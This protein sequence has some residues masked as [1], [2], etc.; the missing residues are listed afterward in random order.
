M[1][2]EQWDVAELVEPNPDYERNRAYAKDGPYRTQLSSEE[3]RG[4]QSWVKAN[5]VPTDDSDTS[6][7]DM[8]GFYRGMKAGDEHARTGVNQNDGKLHFSDYYKTPYHKSFSRESQWATDGAPSWNDQDQLVDPRGNVVFDERAKASN[9]GWEIDTLTEPGD[10]GKGGHGLVGERATPPAPAQAPESS[11]GEVLEQMPGEYGAQ[12]AKRVS[13]AKEFVADEVRLQARKELWQLM[14]L[15]EAVRRARDEG[16]NLTEDPDVVSYAKRLG[17]RPDTFVRD[18]PSMVNLSQDERLSRQRSARDRYE[19]A[20]EDALKQRAT[21]T[22][23]Q[24]ESAA[25]RPD[26][27]PW[28]AKSIV[29]DAMQSV[30]DLLAGIGAGVAGGPPAGLAVLGASVAPG[31]YSDARDMG[32]DPHKAQIYTGL[33]TMAEIAPELPVFE[34]MLHNPVGQEAL[35]KTV[36]GMILKQTGKVAQTAAFEGVSESVT[37]ALEIGI[38]EGLIDKNTPLPQ[39][40]ERIARAGVVG[41]AMGAGVAGVHQTLEGGAERIAHGSERRVPPEMRKEP[42]LGDV[43][44]PVSSATTPTIPDNLEAPRESH[45]GDITVEAGGQ[46]AQSVDETAPESAPVAQGAWEVADLVEPG[47]PNPEAEH[48][49]FQNQPKTAATAE[50]PVEAPPVAGTIA[51][52]APAEASTPAVAQ[53]TEPVSVRTEGGPEVPGA[54]IPSPPE[55]GNNAPA[56]EAATPASEWEVEHTTAPVDEAAHAAAT[57]PHNALPEPTH[58]QKEAG[59]YQKGHLRLHGLDISIENP[60]GSTRSSHPGAKTQ[61]QVQ[62]P[63]HYG[64]VRRT[65]GADGEHVDITLGPHA[66]DASKPVFVIDQ[67]R[68][69]TLK[70]D[71]TKSFMGFDSAEQVLEAYRGSFEGDFGKKMAKGVTPRQFTL[72]QYKD[73]LA[74]GDHTKPVAEYGLAGTSQPAAQDQK[75]TEIGHLSSPPV[76]EQQ[77]PIADELNVAS[78]WKNELTEV[79][80]QAV[81]QAAGIKVPKRMAWTYLKPEER[82]KV[83]AVRGTDNDPLES[84]RKARHKAAE[85]WDEKV[86]Q[87]FDISVEGRKVRVKVSSGFGVGRAHVEYFGSAISPTG[88]RSTWQSVPA[89]MTHEEVQSS[90]QELGPRLRAESLK[91]HK[92]SAKKPSPGDSLAA[93]MARGKHFNRFVLDHGDDPDIVAAWKAVQSDYREEEEHTD[94]PPKSFLTG[95]WAA[96][97]GYKYDAIEHF[98][99]NVKATELPYLAGFRAGGGKIP[100]VAEKEPAVEAVPAPAQTE[101]RGRQQ[102]TV[103]GR[104]GEPADVGGTQSPEGVPAAGVRGAEEER[105]ARADTAAPSPLDTAGDGRAAGARDEPGRGVAA[106]TGEVPDHAG[107]AGEHPAGDVGPDADRGRS[108]LVPPAT[109]Q[110]ERRAELVPPATPA[111]N[112]IITAADHLGEGGQKTKA[113]QNLDAI[114]ILK[115]LAKSGAAATR[116]QQEALVKYVGWGGIPQIFDTTKAEWEELRTDLAG[117]LTPEEFAAARRS[118]QD[119]HYTSETVVRGMWRALSRMGFNGGSV[120]E[121]SVGVGHFFGMMPAEQRTGTRAVGVELDPIT[122]GIAKLLYPGDRVHSPMGFQDFAVA[123]DS[124]DLAIGNPPFGNQSLYDR[125]RTELNP[126]SIHNYFFAKSINA[127]RPGG[128]L[129]MVVSNYFLDAQT[130]SAREY[131]SQRANLVA[132]IRLP[133]TA[134]K[135]NAGT[136]VVTD[137]I[138]LRKRMP[139]EESN[140]VEWKD[141]VAITDPLGGKSIIVNRWIADHPQNVLGRIER[142]GKMRFREEPSVTPTGD[143]EQQ[144]AEAVDR[145]PANAYTPYRMPDGGVR[146]DEVLASLSTDIAHVKP[147][148]VFQDPSTGDLLRRIP[149]ENGKQRAVVVIP[150]SESKSIPFQRVSKMV[151]LRDALLEQLRLEITD[152]KKK[153]IEDHRKALASAYGQFVKKYGYFNDPANKAL[154]REDPEWPLLLS[155]EE[156]Y[157]KGLSATVAKRLGVDQRPRSARPGPILTR[158]VRFPRKPPTAAATNI[159]ALALSLAERGKVDPAYMESLRGKSA[160][161]IIEDLGDEVFL[162]PEDGYVTRD[163]YLSGNVKKKLAWA[164]SALAAGDKRYAKNVRALKAI[165]PADVAAAKIGVRMGAP[166][167]PGEVMSDWAEHLFGKDT[168]SEFAYVPARGGWSFTLKAGD[169]VALKQK[170]GSKRWSGKDI[171]EAQINNQPIRIYDTH[172]DGSRTFNEEATQETQAMA[173]RMEE[174]W[175]EWVFK[176]PERRA[177]VARLYNDKFNTN[178]RRRYDGSHLTRNPDGTEGA[179]IGANPAIQLRPHQVNAIWRFVQDGNGLLDHVVGAGKTFGIIG[180]VMER[181]RLGLARRQMIAVPNHLVVQWATDFQRLYPGAKV[182]ATTKKDFER[183][184]RQRLFARIATGDFDAVIVAHSSFGFIELPMEE[185]RAYIGEMVADLESSIRTVEA[186][187]GKSVRSIKDMEKLK[188]KLTARLQERLE[189]RQRDKV[190]DFEQLGIDGL[191]VDELHEFKNLAFATSLRNIAGLGDTSGSQKAEDLYVKVRY[192]QKRHGGEGFIGASGTPFTNTLAEMFT[193]QRYFQYDRLRELGITHFDSWQS[194]FARR[195]TDWEIGATGAGYKLRERLAKFTN[196][197]QLRE[198]YREFADVVLRRHID[199]DRKARG[200][201]PLTP[202]IKGGKPELSVAERSPAQAM[203]MDQLIARAENLKGQNQRRKGADNMLAITGDARKAGLD[204]RLI[205]PSAVD[206]PGSKVNEAVRRALDTYNRWTSRLGTQL[207]FCDLSTPKNARAAEAKELRAL[208]ERAEAGDE[209]AEEKLAT[210]TVEELDALSDSAF[211]VYND[212]KQKLIAGGVPE[213]EIAFIH[214]YGTDERKSDL[215][216]AVR[217]GRIRILLGSTK[218]MGAGT[219]VQTRLVALHHLDAPWKPSELEQRE[220]RIVRQGNAFYE[221]NDDQLIERIPGFEV[222]ITRYATKQTYDAYM[223]QT[224][225]NKARFIEQFRDEDDATEAEDIAMQA[226]SAAEMKAASSGNPLIMEE[227]QLRSDVDQLDNLRRA[228]AGKQHDLQDIVKR[229]QNWAKVREQAIA[230]VDKDIAAMQPVPVAPKNDKARADEILKARKTLGQQIAKKLLDTKRGDVSLGM[231]RGF[232]VQG[233][234]SDIAGAPYLVVEAATGNHISDFRQDDTVD[235]LGVMRRLDNIIDAFPD[236]REII[237]NRSARAQAEMAS[238]QAEIGK[239]FER[240]AE[241]IQKKQ[242]H[243]E[244]LKELAAQDKKKPAEPQLGDTPAMSLA[245]GFYSPVERAIEGLDQTRASGPQ[246]Y[247][248]LAASRSVKGVKQEE[249]DWLGLKEWLGDRERVTKEELLDFVRANQIRVTEDVTNDAERAANTT[250]WTRYS[251]RL[252]ALGWSVG[253]DMSGDAL[254]LGAPNGESYL[255][256]EDALAEIPDEQ[257]REIARQMIDQNVAPPSLG[258]EYIPGTKYS[259]YTLGGGKNYHELLLTLPDVHDGQPLSDGQVPLEMR[260]QRFTSRHWNRFNVLAH[261]RFAEHIGADGKR[262]LFIEELQSDWHQEGR[263]EGYRTHP[264]PWEVFDTKT[265][266]VLSR[267]ATQEEARAESEATRRVNAADYGQQK[268]VPDAPFKTTWPELVMKRMIRWAAENGFE[269]VAWAPGDVHNER[270][271]L[272][273][274]VDRIVYNRLEAPDGSSRWNLLVDMK[275]STDS[276][277]REQISSEGVAELVGQEMLQKMEAGAGAPRGNGR[278][279][280][281]LDL[282]VGGQ[283]N[284]TFYDAILPSV[285]QKLIKKWGGKVVET[286]IRADHPSDYG[287][288]TP[289]AL[290]QT[291]H[292]FDL[293]PEMK[294]AALGGLPMFKRVKVVKGEAPRSRVPTASLRSHIANLAKSMPMVRVHVVEGAKELPPGR[295]RDHV[296]QYDDRQWHGA[297]LRDRFGHRDIFVNALGVDSVADA[298]RNIWHEATHRG[299]YGALGTR[300]YGRLLDHLF[301]ALG[302]APTFKEEIEDYFPKGWDRNK[303]FDRQKVVDEYL[304]RWSERV[305]E[306]GFAATARRAIASIKAWVDRWLREHG[307]RRSISHAEIESTLRAMAKHGLANAAPTNI[308][309]SNVVRM[310]DWAGRQNA[311]RTEPTLGDVPPMSVP[312]ASTSAPSTLHANPITQTYRAYQTMAT[313]WIDIWNKKL[314]WRYGPLG[315][316]SK[317]NLYLTERYLTLGRVAKAQEIG[318]GIYDAFVKADPHDAQA[319]Y[320]YLTNAGATPINIRDVELRRKAQQVKNLIDQVGQR[321]VNSGL[322]S[323]QAYLE[324]QD[325][326]LPRVYL[327]HMLGDTV[328]RALGNGKKVSDMGYL[329]QRKDIP[330]DV[331]ELILGEITDPAFLASFSLSRT[332]RDLAILDFLERISQEGDWILAGQMVRWR[333]HLVT[334]QWLRSEA[335]HIRDQ[336]KMYQPAVATRALALAQQMEQAANKVLNQLAPDLKAFRQVPDSVRY[337]MLRGMW[338]RKEIYDD[339]IGA[340]RFLD[341]ENAG[342]AERMLGQGGA[343]TKVTQWWK[344]SKVALNPPT[345]IRNFMTN[346]VLLHLSGVP[347]HKVY[348]GALLGRAINDLLSQGKYTQIAKKYGLWSTSFANVEL[349]EIKREWLNLQARR[350]GN[351]GSWTLA[352]LKDFAGAIVEKAGDI[353]QFSEAVTKMQ[354]IIDAMEREGL[355]ESEAVLEAQKWLFDYSL[356]PRSIAYLRN[357]P[358]G[359]PF[360]TFNYKV[361]PRLGEV[362]LRHPLRLAMYIALPWLLAGLIADKYDVDRDD[363]QKLLMALPEWLREKSGVYLLPY[364]DSLDRWQA[365]NLGYY[366]P[367]TMFSDFANKLKAGKP[368]EALDV[369]GIPSGP[370]LDASAALATNIDPFTKKEIVNSSDP[371]AEQVAQVL[372]YMWNL[373]APPWA[374][375]QGDVSK[376]AGAATGQ[377]NAKTGDPQQTLTQ[378]AIRLLGVGIYPIEPEKTRQANLRHMSFEIDELAQRMGEK[379]RDRNLTE[380]QRA[381]VVATYK[382][383]IQE[384]AARMKR[385]ADES[386]VAPPLQ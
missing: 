243:A 26:M 313:N 345:Q 326:Y 375:T 59:N 96:K 50:P 41:A 183:E 109:E 277:R 107:R 12:L 106:G 6:D 56:P 40:L 54:A 352:H 289:G 58:A 57:S 376:V 121:P 100:G 136:D 2:A 144:L 344:M 224:I 28:S 234:W 291:V 369:A 165:Q 118:T 346:H 145:L 172:A 249:L 195:K 268:G 310:A 299:F 306:P 340:Q 148:G 15:P 132:A 342:F 29:Y 75:K 202:P 159:D 170:W 102:R 347:A 32:V 193:M 231:Y 125:V 79:G 296:M 111:G 349:A 334:P 244:V 138:V 337:G 87:E 273:R 288:D 328:F 230:A 123:D 315:K 196:L 292:S 117:Q 354:K 269:R 76:S 105:P 25:Y 220:G 259:A 232:K 330:K 65:T 10:L 250:D 17:I 252:H 64:Y 302:G 353:Y 256:E 48:E 355:S 323:Q 357:A 23:L 116:A 20:T 175:N 363:V 285:V 204:I 88:Y 45:P 239:P 42:E 343:A 331:R 33:M 176:E 133:N 339:L 188:D 287:D 203:Y 311:P 13:G 130:Q 284:R 371:P 139:G 61:W 181:K 112:Y 227:V 95:W 305:H 104:A 22:E 290:R 282:K 257:V 190:V 222:D 229:N 186:V 143:L 164:E 233:E 18:W 72:D 60:A 242:R 141:T 101:P 16:Y 178:V 179:L 200:L 329:K 134:F 236:Q 37:E 86:K 93:S 110:R 245:R 228:H 177:A 201:P 46:S 261:V 300:D 385:Y 187:E 301:T 156:S 212:V 85:E 324:H 162:D 63:H 155:I 38:E 379:A 69:G 185:Y 320:D 384:H 30:P 351:P 281:G 152:A 161:S 3:E 338:V 192:L 129:T 272:E 367:W 147:F 380:A 153:D 225:E 163:A 216:E 312:P 168:K 207:V 81:I 1:S 294:Q 158:R 258:G 327:R 119:A 293:T 91:E 115:D 126:F 47:Q 255:M 97:Q 271:G 174:E 77:T 180:V 366:F 264:E 276:V 358:I 266:E 160:D 254:E 68:P 35:K 247:A 368:R 314:G 322:L 382:T 362:A 198:M 359:I 124:F 171:L 265:G 248:T 253:T 335:E 280:A 49:W 82:A 364:K 114:R 120:L 217:A 235:P 89:D 194:T 55:S 166:W 191:Y 108:A 240:E 169:Q 51:G 286:L 173:T 84:E 270:F 214:D 332:M 304:A 283:G 383:L 374:G 73:W 122:G 19:T 189:A 80:R 275:N 11:W 319:I 241:F 360:A 8:R 316:L 205:F 103:K 74:N 131:I 325:A 31:F 140:A 36:S 167:I 336:A 53:P 370:I 149:D 208:Q 7:Y 215:F 98:A 308:G 99:M 372:G 263:T 9:D 150:Q 262:T 307:W 298:E 274:H 90:V 39:A 128:L 135:G 21:S 142:S 377:V 386:K 151:S 317:Q 297:V 309:A 83:A 378:A 137:I 154:M 237:E 199:D 278:E 348:S 246:W 303:P 62:M 5:D 24:A 295:E 213:R 365:L 223:W 92:A 356:V 34:L 251:E 267:H 197:P 94:Q 206:H 210:Y 78:W 71:E 67:N 44:A 70:F 341:P 221:G 66:E 146:Q 157:D 52:P 4:Y 321:L 350:A 318:R 182:L 260:G 43:Q 127:V 238:A 209:A 219:N 279:L 226:A 113:R 361:L 27:R 333:G 211:D 218:K 381:K 14:V 184:N 373:A